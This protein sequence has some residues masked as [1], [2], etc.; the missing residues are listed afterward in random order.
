MTQPETT[1]LH[2]LAAKAGIQIDWEDAHQLAHTVDAEVLR[3][4]LQALQLPA[5]SDTD[6]KDSLHR[7]QEQA[8]SCPPLLTA[9]VKTPLELPSC[10]SRSSNWRLELES[11]E[12]LQGKANP[13][14]TRTLTLPETVPPGYHRLHMGEHS[15]TLAV[16][17]QRCV[18]LS[19]LCFQDPARAWGLSAQLYSLR[20]ADQY[21]GN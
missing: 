10:L 7:L 20:G 18:P 19:S 6:I 11:G 4:V 12:F 15:I 17:P 8:E 16:A 2:E 9:T 5:A 3:N 14:A 13:G 1:N 21:A